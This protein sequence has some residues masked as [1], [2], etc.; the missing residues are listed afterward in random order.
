MFFLWVPFQVL[1]G[2]TVDEGSAVL[3]L[4]QLLP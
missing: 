3:N 4:L 1:S 2:F